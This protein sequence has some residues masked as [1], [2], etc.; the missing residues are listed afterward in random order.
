MHDYRPAGPKS[1]GILPK[2]Q[3][4]TEPRRSSNLV[5]ILFSLFLPWVIFMGCFSV[6]SF[7]LH[8]ESASTA[9]ALCF[10]LLA[11]VLICGYFALAA[12]RKA[13]AGDTESEATWLV[14]LFV[15]GLLAWL[16]G[17]NAG[18]LNFA[19]SMRPYYDIHQ[20]N[21]YPS[22]DP[23]LFQGNQLM[24]AGQIVFTR[25]AH[26]D[27]SKGNGFKND[28]V[29][30]VA[31]IVSGTHPQEVY[32][33]WA[34]GLNCCSGHIP[35]YACGEFSNPDAHSGLRLMLDDYRPYFHLAVQQAE[36]AFN[37][38]SPHPVFLHWMQDPAAEVNAYQDAGVTHFLFAVFAFFVLQL[39]LVVL[40][41]FLFARSL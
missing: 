31:P 21:V 4:L 16:I 37:L 9:K 36:A 2:H 32:D 13:V 5:A 11:L 26:I 39:F 3:K 24:D 34:V 33:F 28:D 6:M 15:T 18:N 30:C 14:F 20:L 41:V 27:I 35:D 8:Y 17:Y 23:A 19:A 1:Y 29:Y 25:D 38:R 40:A 12:V 22:V 10:C 7:S